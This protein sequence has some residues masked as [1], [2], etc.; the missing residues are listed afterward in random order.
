MSDAEALRALMDADRWIDRVHHQRERLP[1]ATE[2]ASVEDELRGLVV[3]LAG[4]RAALA[5]VRDAYEN[6]QQESERL[7]RRETDLS[8]ALGASTANAREL[9]ALQTEVS[10]VRER[11]SDAEDREL[12]LL[13]AVEPLDEAVGAI[14]KRAQ[15]AIERREELRRIIGELQASLDEEV[16]ALE[17]HRVTLADEL[18]PALRARYDHALARD[19]TSGA[20]QVVEG[21]CDGCR[22]QLSPL[23]RDRWKAQAAGTFLSCPSCGRLL[24]P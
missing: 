19:G 5:P 2:L 17:R 20:A 3:A 11:L 10:Q 21:R 1:E 18:E 16:A 6:A 12:E 23:D 14:K 9:A 13:L 4:A 22:I 8:S 15:P 7:R 24:L